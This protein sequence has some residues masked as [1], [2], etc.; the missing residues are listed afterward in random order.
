MDETSEILRDID[1]VGRIDCVPTI[2]EVVARTTGL[3]FAAIARVTDTH[4]TA[5]AVHDT[6]EFGLQ[7]GGELALDT[8]ICNEIRQH[9]QPIAFGHAS[10]HPQFSTH[11]TPRLYG[12]ESY[13]SVPIFRASGEFFGTLCA[14]DPLPSTVDNPETLTTLQL[15]A[16]LIGMQLESDEKFALSQAALHTALDVATIREAFIRDVSDDFKA[17]I[18]SVLME[19]YL[20]KT[21]TDIDDG[22]RAS[23][24]QIEA[25]I[26][27]MSSLLD[28]IVDFAHD[29]LVTGVPMAVTPPATL[30]AELKRVLSQ[31][32]TTYPQRA[33]ATAVHVDHAVE[34]DAARIGQLLANLAINV[35]RHD[36]AVQT[37]S[38]RITT[39]SGD[40]RL[41]VRAD[42]LDMPPDLFGTAAGVP[43][44]QRGAERRSRWDF[45]I[46]DEIAR[47][48]G[49]RLE[50]GHSNGAGELLFVMPLR[51][52]NA[53]QAIDV[54]S[55]RSVR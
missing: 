24:A 4:W 23:V 43:R 35:L 16:Q 28:N 50:A 48:H 29:K 27:R 13:I 47:A 55:Q 15:F 44:V 9:R 17:P 39:D 49:G 53:T 33:L 10:A 7:P 5:C 30:S 6:I 36:D 42:G 54:T 19:T 31:V 46:A 51:A 14:I 37:V 22:T 20:I 2:L 34:C 52:V 3:R 45:F 26:W 38:V 21:A 25:D 40:F 8:T 1:A 41:Q 18:Q 11:H 32:A 12:L